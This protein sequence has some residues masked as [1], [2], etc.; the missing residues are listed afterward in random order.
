MKIR[1]NKDCDKCSECVEACQGGV[2]TDEIIQVN[3]QAVIRVLFSTECTYCESCMACC[4]QNAITVTN[5]LIE[6]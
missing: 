6:E 1:I 3:N 4:P 2:L 5:P